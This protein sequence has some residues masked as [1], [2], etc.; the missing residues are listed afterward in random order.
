[1]SAE[2]PDS[3]DFDDDYDNHIDDGSLQSLL[4]DLD[5]QK[6]KPSTIKGAEPAWRRLEKLKEQQATKQL[7][8]DFDDYDV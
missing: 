2:K 7:T 4:R 3:D 1:M 5:T 8:E 6:R